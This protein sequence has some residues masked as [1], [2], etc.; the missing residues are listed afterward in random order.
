MVVQTKRHLTG[1]MYYIPCYCGA[2]YI[3]QKD[4][5]AKTRLVER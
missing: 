4:R 5:W 2:V 1:F 3:V